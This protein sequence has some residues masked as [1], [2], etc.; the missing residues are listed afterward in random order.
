MIICQPLVLKLLQSTKLC[1]VRFPSLQGLHNCGDGLSLSGQQDRRLRR[2]WKTACCGEGS[3]QEPLCQ[4]AV[5]GSP[6]S[7]GLSEF[8]EM[9]TYSHICFQWL[10]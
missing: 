9:D 7:W 8:C 4:A 3:E 1:K 10:L 6:P 5:T 2:V